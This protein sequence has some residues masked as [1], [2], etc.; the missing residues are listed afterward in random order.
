M[1]STFAW[2]S[3]SGMLGSKIIT[4]GPNSGW[5]DPCGLADAVVLIV[6]ATNITARSRMLI[7]MNF[8]IKILLLTWQVKLS[9]NIRSLTVVAEHYNL[10]NLVSGSV[11]FNITRRK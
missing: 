4:F 10:L 3:L 6:S 1:A 2:I 5:P 8:D 9:C 11:S 7:D